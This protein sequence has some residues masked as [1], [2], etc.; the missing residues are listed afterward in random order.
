MRKV[1]SRL[2]SNCTLWTIVQLQSFLVSSPSN[3]FDLDKALN[4]SHS[5]ISYIGGYSRLIKIINETAY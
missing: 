3:I 5:L 2:I 1:P 4:N